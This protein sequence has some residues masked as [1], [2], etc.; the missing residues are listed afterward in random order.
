[1]RLLTSLLSL[2]IK[3]RLAGF[4]L[5]CFLLGCED[6][7][8]VLPGQAAYDAG[9][10]AQMQGLPIRAQEYYQR[11]A[12]QGSLPA[13]AARLAMQTPSESTV[14][15]YHWLQ[16]LPQPMQKSLQPFYQQ[17]GYQLPVSALNTQRVPAHQRCQLTIQPV[18]SAQLEKT[19]WLSL[20]SAWQ[21][22]EFLQ[23]LPIC[24]LPAYQV[25]AEQLR[26]SDF[27]EQRLTCELSSL[28]DLVLSGHFQQLLIMSGRGTANY[29][30]GVLHLPTNADL[31]LLR[32]EF[33]HIVG[34]IDEYALAHPVAQSECKPGRMTPNL[35]FSKADLETYVRHFKVS[36]QKIAL[37]P[38]ATCQH[39]GLQAY[40]V[41]AEDSHLQHF[42]LDV[43]S[44]YQQLIQQQL[45]NSAQFMPVHYYF[46]Y[47]ARQQNNW[48]LWQAQ[49]QRAAAFDYAPAKSALEEW[50]RRSK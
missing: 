12:T 16:Q 33:S 10:R 30:N 50:H 18:F 8:P 7:S 48:S 15:L 45:A 44:L 31:A 19:Q 32:H 37:T 42:E 13:V 17:L 34:F 47:L 43:P 22:D 49:M 21:Q 23:T 26:C 38:V 9:Q 41:V 2:Q 1:M 20:V 5:C 24:F 6:A 29:N 39:V 27:P 14:A 4:F 36:A 40:R 46:A 11:A 28:Q 35:L 25:A 3:S